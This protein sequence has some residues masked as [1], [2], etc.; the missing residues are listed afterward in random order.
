VAINNVYPI[1]P[2]TLDVTQSENT[3]ESWEDISQNDGTRPSVFEWA[4]RKFLKRGHTTLQDF[5]DDHKLTLR[6]RTSFPPTPTQFYQLEP[7][8][9]STTKIG[10][11]TWDD[12]IFSKLVD[13]L[14]IR[15]IEDGEA[16]TDPLVRQAREQAGDESYLTTAE[17]QEIILEYSAN[18]FGS[19]GF[20][21]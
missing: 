16:G 9:G 8:K 1:L 11:R 6:K 3:P 20:G 4:H 10:T 15:S 21:G 18:H 5:L 17:R 7:A 14:A 2:D 12:S 13:D 19:R